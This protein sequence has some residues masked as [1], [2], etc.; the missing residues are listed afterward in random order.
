M[1]RPDVVG[2]LAL[3][4]VVGCCT[5]P[6]AREPPPW[7]TLPEVVSYVNANNVPLNFGLKAHD[8]RAEVTLAE[9]AYVLDGVMLLFK[10]A[11]FFLQLTDPFGNTV[12]ELGT[13]G[14]EYW[15]WVKP[16]MD[17]LWWGK[18]EHLDKP[19]AMSMPIRPD[20]LMEALGVADLPF[21]TRGPA[22][23]ALRVTPQRNELY[24][25]RATDEGQVF[26]RKEFRV[27]RWAPFL[28][29]EVVHRARDGR[30][31]L[32]TGLSDYGPVRSE[33][34]AG[35]MMARELRLE[36]PLE[37]SS[38]RLRIGTWRRLDLVDADAEAFVFPLADGM[39][40]RTVEQ[41]DRACE[42]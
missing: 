15:L 24:F 22:G 4:P 33:S 1:R 25:L 35:P 28:I 29:R 16:E 13:N 3:L 34:A 18:H 2:C 20:H 10:P 5:T 40:F 23:P 32:H 26:I 17:K 6:P 38:I 42:P 11:H 21:D 30:V 37:K 27:D 7:L 36:W 19:C 39:T 8:V 41:I 12:M 14:R 9:H 31:L